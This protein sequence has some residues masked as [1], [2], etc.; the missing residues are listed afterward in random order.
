[1]GKGL[2]IAVAESCTGG[3]IGQRLTSV[4]GSSAYFERGVVT[5]S[6]RAKVDLLKVPEALI[7]AKGS[8]SG[9]VAQAMAEGV[10]ELSGADLGLAVT[11]IAGPTGGTKEKPIGLVYLALADKKTAVVRSHLFSGDR[12]GIRYRASQAALDLLRRYLSGKALE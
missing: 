2:S 11:G 5:Y 6:D 9:E 12:D 1:K 7:R 3:L 4:P 8:V 10:R